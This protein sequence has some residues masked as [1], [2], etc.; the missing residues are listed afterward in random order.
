MLLIDPLEM[1]PIYLKQAWLIFKCKN[2]EQFKTSL[3][4]ITFYY[5]CYF[6]WKRSKL[7]GQRRALAWQS[8]PR[9]LRTLSSACCSQK[10]FLLP[11]SPLQFRSHQ[12]WPR[13]PLESCYEDCE[14]CEP[15]ESKEPSKTCGNDSSI[16]N[17]VIL[18]DCCDTMS[19]STG[20]SSRYQNS[21]FDLSGR[22]FPTYASVKSSH[23]SF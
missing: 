23:G 1:D 22:V 5:F 20:S 6:C 7:L 13:Q 12:W 19:T 2:T 8:L 16:D 15:C 4:F 11:Q 17:L 14:N 9:H 21:H 18:T 10:V 3:A